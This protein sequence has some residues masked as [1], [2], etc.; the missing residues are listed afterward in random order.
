MPVAGD[1]LVVL[2]CFFVMVGRAAAAAAAW[3]RVGGVL[4]S[5]LAALV[6]AVG[7]LVAG[8]GVPRGGSWYA[9]ACCFRGTR[10]RGPHRQALSAV[11]HERPTVT[12]GGRRRRFPAA[13][14]H[15]LAASPRPPPSPARRVD[16]ALLRHLWR[17]GAL[18]LRRCG[19]AGGAAAWRVTAHCGGRGHDDPPWCAGGAAWCC[20][21]PDGVSTRRARRCRWRA[22]VRW[23]K[24]A[25]AVPP[26]PGRPARPCGRILWGWFT[27]LA[28]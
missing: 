1:P 26:P 3:R 12:A 2:L 24:R 27:P 14:H 8:G 18:G 21:G 25:R 4:T 11:A 7:V 16:A 5:A 6:G 20:G 22:W 28:G 10:P 9:H 17:C 13:G 23:G 19:L 15:P